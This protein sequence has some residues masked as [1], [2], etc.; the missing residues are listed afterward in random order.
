MNDDSGHSTQKSVFRFCFWLTV[1]A[2]LLG[3]VATSLQL[4]FFKAGDPNAFVTSQILRSI[5][6]DSAIAL[7][8]VLALALVRKST[9]RRLGRL[10]RWLFTWR[11]FKRCLL[12]L[13]GLL[14]LLALGY[15]EEDWRGWRKWE[16]C[17]RGWEAGGEHL[18]FAFFIPTPV[19]DEENFALT[20]VV[21]SC[22]RRFLDHHGR[23]IQPEDTNVVDRLHMEIYRQ[24]LPSNTNLQ[25]GFWRQS[26]FIDLKAW[27]EYY[28]TLLSTNRPDGLPVTEEMV[29]LNAN[30]FPVAPQPQT[31]AA[32]V[33]FA[34]SKFSSA[35]EE[36][37]QASR[38]P[39]SRFPLNYATNNP[40]EIIIPHHASLKR[41]AMAL[42]LRAVAELSDGHAE[43][44]LADIRLMLRLADSI[45]DEP[46][47]WSLRSRLAIVDWAIEPIWEGL[48]RR[49]W[50]EEQLVA[51]ERDLAGFDAISD[52]SRGLRSELAFDLKLLDY[53]RT[54]RMANSI[55]CM[56]G[57]TMFWPTVAYRL[58][59]SG[60]FNMSKVT[61][62]HLFQAA[63]PTPAEL[64]QKILS[65][66][67]G[68]RFRT[69]ERLERNSR[70]PPDNWSLVF[71]P[72]LEREAN[73]CAL[74]QASVDLARVACALERY[75]RA[76]G[77]YPKS[78]DAL[79]PE[80][81]QKIPHDIINGQPLRYRRMEL[82]SFLLYSVG[83]NEHDDGGT[84]DTEVPFAYPNA[85]GDWVWRYPAE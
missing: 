63:L 83:W 39:H 72:A 47:T 42:S 8:G 46:F 58:S 36:L 30:E 48:A 4:A 14:V 44:A 40:A 2:L 26:T 15:V 23:R 77:N 73:H 45:Q 18:D 43:D 69:A 76:N 24:N 3:I 65:P 37:R 21:A 28:R 82:G 49:Q 9:A 5:L 22:Y 74:T 35:I 66:D 81:I 70:L 62:A 71:V 17:R 60:W 38:L 29:T 57:D 75:R 6:I 67:I 12:V 55:T 13:A 34:L 27:Q 1:V 7:G 10:L 78:L 64:S 32:D 84:P 53:L 85:G 51:L 52:Y 41:S 59:P 54:E 11:T 19:P 33:L 79:T 16:N 31:P 56:C 25:V 68:R 20:P 50:T 80:F 61:A